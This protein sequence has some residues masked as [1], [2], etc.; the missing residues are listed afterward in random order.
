MPIKD[1][2]RREKSRKAAEE[3]AS[4]LIDS[5]RWR[6]E[7]ADREEARAEAILKRG[8]RTDDE[9][10]ESADTP[11]AQTLRARKAILSFARENRCKEYA[12]TYQRAYKVL[13]AIVR[14]W[15]RKGSPAIGV[16]IERVRLEKIT[17]LKVSRV[18][19]LCTLLQGKALRK[20]GRL[21]AAPRADD[22]NAFL[23]VKSGKGRSASTFK[24]HLP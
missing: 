19:E 10:D 13:H 5:A 4:R 23:D 17:G 9:L 20:G 16:S 1:A 15:R 22:G 6:R 8:S 18:R 11:E 2:E 12:E 21:Y 24:P 3:A 14:E 7:K